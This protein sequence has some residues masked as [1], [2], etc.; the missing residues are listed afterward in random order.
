MKME[1]VADS[2]SV[3]GQRLHVFK[4]WR[5]QAH[6]AGRVSK[7]RSLVIRTWLHCHIKWI[8]RAWRSLAQTRQSIQM[9]VNRFEMTLP[10][11]LIRSS[12]HRWHHYVQQQHQQRYELANAIQHLNMVRMRH[13]FQSWRGT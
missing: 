9:D 1:Q 8:F 12:L 10:Q 3:R 4:E 2:H 13:I 5:R 7:L 11:R 6:I